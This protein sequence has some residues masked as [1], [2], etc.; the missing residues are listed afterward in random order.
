MELENQVDALRLKVRELSEALEAASSEVA[1]RPPRAN[2]RIFAAGLIGG[3]IVALAR[4]Q[5]P[6]PR[7]QAVVIWRPQR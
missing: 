7:S 5:R 4:G 6:R 3:D 1:A 2:S